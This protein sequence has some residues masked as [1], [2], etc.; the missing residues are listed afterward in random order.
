MT[1][2]SSTSFSTFAT[3]WA[4]IGSPPSRKT[5]AQGGRGTTR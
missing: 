2:A 1:A 3:V 5:S 4:W